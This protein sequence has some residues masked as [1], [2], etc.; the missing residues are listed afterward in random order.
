[1]GKDPYK[2]WAAIFI[3]T[4]MMS[5]VLIAVGVFSYFNVDQSIADA[6][7]Q[8]QNVTLPYDQKALNSAVKILDDRAANRESI[9]HSVVPFGDPS[10]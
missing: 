5:L 1:M 2:D 4:C 6:S 10:I 7:L 8:T 9:V 3:A